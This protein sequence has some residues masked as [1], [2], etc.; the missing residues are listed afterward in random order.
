MAKALKIAGAVVAVA[1]LAII[2]GGLAAGASLSFIMSAGF[3]VGTLTV[4]GL[5]AVGAA[6]NTAGSLLSP[7]PKAPSTSEANANRLSVS[8]ELRAFRKTVI[9]S[10]AMATDLRDQEWSAD[11]SLLHRFIVCASHRVHAIREIWFDDKLAW[12]ATGGVQGPYVGY[13]QVVAVLEG[14]AA[15]AINIGAEIRHSRCCSSCSG[16]ASRTLRTARGNSRSTR[17]SRPLASILPASSP[18][19]TCATSP[20]RVPMARPSRA[21]GWMAFGARATARVWS[22]T[23]SRRR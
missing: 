18:P 19:P 17:A 20:S 4:G 2:T 9:G 22:S 14:S 7:K 23:T 15:N 10:T 5:I 21:T 3:G 13:L 6:L 12:T 8:M 1:G 16:G 11:Q